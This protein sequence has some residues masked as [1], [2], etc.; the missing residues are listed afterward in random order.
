MRA[1]RYNVAS[2]MRLH[3]NCYCGVEVITVTSGVESTT[4]KSG[5]EFITVK[6]GVEY[7]TVKNEVQIGVESSV[8]E[9]VD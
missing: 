7:M 4:V 9:I 2:V 5:V 1:T 3:F 8:L 6:S